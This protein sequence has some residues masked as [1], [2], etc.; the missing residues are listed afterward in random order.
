MFD[1][2]L[3]NVVSVLEVIGDQAGLERQLEETANVRVEVTQCLPK[4]T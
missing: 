1:G 4:I 3:D 2:E